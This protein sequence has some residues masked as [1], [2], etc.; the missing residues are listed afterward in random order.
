MQN[1]WGPN[2]AAASVHRGKNGL[3]RH[4]GESTELFLLLSAG[5]SL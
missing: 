2:E 4:K 5:K 3:R 1:T